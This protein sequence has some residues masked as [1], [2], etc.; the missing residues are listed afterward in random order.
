MRKGKRERSGRKYH[1]GKLWI[2]RRNAAFARAGEKCEISGNP[3]LHRIEGYPQRF[4]WQRAADHIFAE[5]WVRRYC[6]GADPHVL[7]NL[8]VVTPSIHAQKTAVEY[9]LFRADM[10]GYRRELNRLGFAPEILDR[11]MKAILQSIPS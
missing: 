1:R 4:R 5:R 6:K 10:L 7:E 11:A 8:V 3:I 2:E 9:L